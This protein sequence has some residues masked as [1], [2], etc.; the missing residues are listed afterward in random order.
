MPFLPLKNSTM[1]HRCVVLLA[2][3]AL[4]ESPSTTSHSGRLN[5]EGCHNETATRTYH[6]HR[7][8]VPSAAPPAQ[9]QNYLPSY[10]RSAYRFTSY[11]LSATRGFYTGRSCKTNVDHVVSLKDAHL[12]GAWQWPAEKKRRFANDK[13]NHVPSCPKINSSKGASV[14][15]DFVRKSSD[16]RGLDYELKDLCA[17]IE[18]YHTVKLTYQLSFK[19]N[20]ASLFSQCG[21]SLPGWQN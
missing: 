7:A 8:S 13:K 15:S 3:I 21:L 16:G 12:S 19:N 4:T 5:G 14:P 10:Q 17:Y 6:C 18:I 2:L 1:C 11:K 9:P 20:N